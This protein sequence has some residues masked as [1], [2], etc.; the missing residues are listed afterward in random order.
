MVYPCLNL[1]GDRCSVKLIIL[2]Q[3]NLKLY[4]DLL[5]GACCGPPKYLPVSYIRS[6]LLWLAV[7]LYLKQ[8]HG[9]QVDNN[10]YRRMM[11]NIGSFERAG[12]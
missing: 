7:P 6:W 5:G 11:K 3:C 9:N 12:L 1:D 8:V 2:K 10:T 4:L